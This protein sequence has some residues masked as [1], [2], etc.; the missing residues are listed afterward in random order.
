[1]RLKKLILTVLVLCIASTALAKPATK[2][3]KAWMKSEITHSS[4][5]FSAKPASGDVPIHYREGTTNG[6]SQSLQMMSDYFPYR[7]REYYVN[8]IWTKIEKGHTNGFKSADEFLNFT[9]TTALK[10]TLNDY[11]HSKLLT[12]KVTTLRGNPALEYLFI[13]DHPANKG[14]IIVVIGA[15]MFD[16]EKVTEFLTAYG[17]G[18]NTPDKVLADYKK[19][20]GEYNEHVIFHT[21]VNNVKFTGPFMQKK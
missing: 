1:M 12:K 19:K 21:F 5:W 6:S 13:A 10:N 18:K 11:A 9:E 3:K 14:E 15:N 4:K 17:N 2:P 8:V 20:D 7:G 16:G